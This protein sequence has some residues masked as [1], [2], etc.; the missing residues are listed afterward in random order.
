[1]R[2]DEAGRVIGFVE[3]PKT[4]SGIA[5]VRTTGVDRRARHRQPRP[6]RTWRAWASTSSTAKRSSTRLD[7]PDYHDFGKEVFPRDPA[8]PRAGPPV[9]RLLGGHRHDQ[10]VLRRQP[11]LAD[12]RR[13]S[14]CRAR[15]R[16]TRRP[17]SCRPRVDGATIR[18]SRS[19]PTAACIE[20]GADVEHSVVGVRCRI[21][22]N[23]VIR[24]SIMIG[25]DFD[26]SDEPHNGTA[27]DP[28]ASATAR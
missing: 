3:K 21:G 16:S 4:D 11:G 24:N 20:A 27:S 13:L 14:T 22:R 5:L 9:R 23:A 10:G 1:M 6:R 7:K 8:P 25:A 12:V 26:D 17:A 2:L 19:W 28:W 18:E 15:A